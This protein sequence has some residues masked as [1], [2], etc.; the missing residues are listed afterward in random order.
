MFDRGRPPI[1]GGGVAR[2]IGYNFPLDVPAIE[3]PGTQYREADY[4]GAGKWMN[5][6]YVPTSPQRQ[7]MGDIGLQNLGGKVPTWDAGGPSPFKGLK[8]G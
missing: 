2:P 3:K 5:D 1:H 7:K 8:R 6:A 4:P